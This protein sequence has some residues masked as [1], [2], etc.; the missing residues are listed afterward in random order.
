[1][2]N[3]LLP[4]KVEKPKAIEFKPIK[5]RSENT[6]LSDPLAAVCRKYTYVATMKPAHRAA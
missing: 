5:L 3:S 1:M 2:S 6:V 4:K